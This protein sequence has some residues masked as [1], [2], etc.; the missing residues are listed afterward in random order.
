[1][2]AL[3]FTYSKHSFMLHKLKLNYLVHICKLILRHLAMELTRSEI[4]FAITTFPGV[5]GWLD[6]YLPKVFAS[7]FYPKVGF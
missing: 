5:S 7:K 6:K 1:M 4:N 2:M 3:M